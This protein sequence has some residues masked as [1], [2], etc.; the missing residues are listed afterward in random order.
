M[1]V[2]ISGYKDVKYNTVITNE[3]SLAEGLYAL[4]SSTATFITYNNRDT[5]EK[6]YEVSWRKMK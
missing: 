3:K 4:N 5:N 1:E 2:N 6:V